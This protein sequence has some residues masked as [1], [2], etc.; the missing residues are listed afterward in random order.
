MRANL[1]AFVDGSA[2]PS[3]VHW[4]INIP[5]VLTVHE[6][7]S[8]DTVALEDIQDLVGISIGAI[9][10]SDG[11]SSG[12]SALGDDLSHGNGGDFHFV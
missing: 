2:H 5:P 1:M 8:P 7:G 6:K 10:K 9:I 4:V 12:C 11:K 3:R